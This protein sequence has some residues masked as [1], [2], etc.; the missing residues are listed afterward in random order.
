MAKVFPQ[1]GQNIAY[2]LRQRFCAFIKYSNFSRIFNFVPHQ[3]RTQ[4]FAVY[5]YSLDADLYRI[6][7]WLLHQ[8][9]RKRAKRAKSV[10]NIVDPYRRTDPSLMMKSI[11]VAAKCRKFDKTIF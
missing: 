4:Q 11:Q 5:E 3:K 9:C 10:R 1:R 8:K 7:D 2:R 6:R